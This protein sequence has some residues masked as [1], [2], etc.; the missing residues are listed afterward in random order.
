MI[1][2]VAE[3]PSVARDI[4]RVLG[5][6]QKGQGFI[7]G[8]TH[9]VT[10]ALGH[11]VTLC[12]PDEVD[13]KYKRWRAEDLPIL[14]PTIP[15]KVIPKTKSQY[16][17]VKKL[18]CDKQTDRV[19]CATD[20]GR[21][22]ELIFRLIYEKSG[23]K[24]PFDRL[25][26]SSMTDQAIRDGLAAMKPGQ[27]YDGLYASALGRAQ[28]DWLV[29][30]NASRAFTLRYG[31]LLS[32]GRVQTP[33]LAILVRRT[34]E[35][36]AFVPETFFTVTASFGDYQGTWFDPD[37]KDQKTSHRI[38]NKEKANEIAKAVRG[39]RATVIDVNREQK[40]ELPPLLYDLT[41]LQRDANSSLGFTASK[42]LACAQAL[43][44]R[45]K[46]ITYP[47]TDSKHL[48]QDMTGKVSGAL[49]ALPVAY[50]PLVSGIP[51]PNGTLPAPRRVY[52]DSRVSD[53]HAIIPTPQK[54]DPARFT[55]DEHA[56]YDLVA[57]R[58]IAAFYPAHEYE[59]VRVI[60][61]S[62]GH[63]FRSTGRTV[64]VSGWKDVIRDKAA[65]KETLPGLAVGDERQTQSASVKQDAT[66]PPPA[67]NDASL[68][69]AMETAGKDI[70]D[71]AL[72][73]QMR[74][75]GLGTP[76]TRAAI[77]E[78]LIRVG[79]VRRQ[80]KALHATL[81]GEQLIAAVPA[82]IASAETTA[83]WEQEL[84]DIARG[85][86]DTQRFDA[87]I[88]RF[89]K[90]LVGYARDSAPD[91][92]FERDKPRGKR[93][94]TKPAGKSLPDVACPLCGKPVLENEKAFGCAGWKEGCGFTLW[95]NAL[96]RGKGPPL[97][98]A[99]VGKLLA[100][101]EVSGSTGV[102]RLRDGQMTYTEKGADQAAV[103]TPIVYHKTRT[104]GKAGSPPAN[105][106]G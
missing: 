52:D 27:A 73:E 26:I 89:T 91:I 76:A 33:T 37:A 69:S 6:R 46:A 34:Q 82:E 15:T 1:V 36:R 95:K 96:E 40:R 103:Q 65:D 5:C 79:Y 24:K 67:H 41:T 11:L 105:K 50:Q 7:G 83:K 71:E 102:I 53:H 94:S 38:A 21:E 88:R 51:K 16:Q 35:I 74:G 72:R 57:R 30:M 47:R 68:L 48:P 93:T 19:I 22:G 9:Q 78:R 3:K 8:D 39:K 28:A 92:A 4:A 66:K 13:Q 55:P 44:E 54:V 84:E 18:I 58:F 81:K 90:F 45:H 86:K 77:I 29:G 14:P 85:K 42:T 99:I 12:E 32:V 75:S 23:C 60:T 59:A 10:W 106:E 2:V 98:A 49:T 97:N 63:N 20:A 56:L 43:Y 70:E 80:G 62:L 17:V 100:S 25:W 87:G 61:Q 101:G 31:A 104:T 64:L